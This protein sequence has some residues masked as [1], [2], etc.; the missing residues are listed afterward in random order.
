MAA[1]KKAYRALARSLHPDVVGDDPAKAARFKQVTE[2]YEVLGDPTSRGAYDRRFQRRTPG[3]MAGGFYPWEGGAAQEPT[4]PPSMDLD[5]LFGDND[6]GFGGGRKRGP[7]TSVKPTSPADQERAR[8]WKRAQS[9][10]SPGRSPHPD[11]GQRARPGHDLDIH[12]RADV[13]ADMVRRGGLVT[14]TYTRLRLTEDR[15][16]LAECDELYDLRV[17][18]GARTGNVLRVRNMGH[19]GGEG[20]FGDLVVELTVQPGAAPDPAP[21]RGSAPTAQG[22]DE[23]DVSIT[24]GEALLGARIRLE[25]PTGAVTFTLPPCTSGGSRFRLRGRGAPDAHGA[26][27]DLMVRLQVHVPAVLDDESRALVEQLIAR[28]PQKVR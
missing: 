23:Q 2:A 15:Q 1:I 10:P 25:T 14:L 28:N 19:H 20:H 11:A 3:R 8:R 9:A 21:S 17:P 5:D 22:P 7:R 27:R 12:L 16:G 24:L 18:P 6:F 4:K 13:P 26:P